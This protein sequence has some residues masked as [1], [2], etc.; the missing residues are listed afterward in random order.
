MVLYYC[1][2]ERLGCAESIIGETGGSIKL[3]MSDGSKQVQLNF[4]IWDKVER[5]G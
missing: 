2:D 3:L 5:I 4:V 1:D